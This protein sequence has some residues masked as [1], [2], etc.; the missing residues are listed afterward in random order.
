MDEK[1]KRER[2]I[3]DLRLALVLMKAEYPERLGAT[4]VM[5]EIGCD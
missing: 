2:D 1:Q 5:A 4:C 3:E